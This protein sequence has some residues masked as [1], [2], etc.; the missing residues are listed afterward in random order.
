MNEFVNEFDFRVNILFDQIIKN[1]KTGNQRNGKYL[2]NIVP[3]LAEIEIGD[4]QR[5]GNGK[6]IDKNEYVQPHASK[7]AFVKDNPPAKSP[8]PPNIV[9]FDANLL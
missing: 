6:R 8:H 7:L 1:D 4:S 3:A 9:V 5:N 2:K